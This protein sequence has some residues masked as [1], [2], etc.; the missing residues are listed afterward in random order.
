MQV[1]KVLIRYNVDL[2]LRSTV[3]PAQEET[4]LETACRWGYTNIVKLFLEKTNWSLDELQK[5][6]K[7]SKNNTIK[8][9]LEKV[10]EA[11]TEEYA[12][13]CLCWFGCKKPAKVHPSSDSTAGI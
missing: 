12:C 1:I 7:A 6:Y 2:K 9:E 3:G 11:Q 10:I 5:A 13:S 8:A 4:V